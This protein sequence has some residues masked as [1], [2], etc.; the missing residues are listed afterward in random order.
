MSVYIRRLTGGWHELDVFLPWNEPPDTTTCLVG[1]KV[2]GGSVA[3]VRN[4][5]GSGNCK[6]SRFLGRIDASFEYCY[7]QTIAKPALLW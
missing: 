3:L 1:G 7:I 2:V 6:T 4:Q 5:A